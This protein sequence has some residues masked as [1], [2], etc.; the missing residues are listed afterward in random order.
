MA[1]G[2]DYKVL[3]ASYLFKHWAAHGYCI[4]D[5]VHLGSSIIGK[6][7]KVDLLVVSPNKMRAF[8]LE[9]KSQDSSGTADE[10]IVYALRDMEQAPFGGCIVYGGDGWSEG[11]L[12]MLQSSQHAVYCMPETSLKQDRRSTLELDQRLAMYFDEWDLLT[13][14]K[15]AF[16]LNLSQSSSVR[17]DDKRALCRELGYDL[18]RGATVAA[19]DLYLKEKGAKISDQRGAEGV[20]NAVAGMSGELK[21]FEHAFKTTAD[22]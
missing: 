10:K 11:V 15:V 8:A 5:E 20:F 22:D 12:H 18:P 17:K 1:S 19:M 14:N 6:A 7:R 4:Y 21:K 13:T 9:C 2:N 16:P 3:I